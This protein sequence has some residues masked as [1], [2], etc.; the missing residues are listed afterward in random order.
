MGP[1]VPFDNDLKQ[2]EAEMFESDMEREQGA[3]SGA[4][5]H[6]IGGLLCFGLIRQEEWAQEIGMVS[7]QY[8]R[9]PFW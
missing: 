9:F 1:L 6:K 5:V 7:H 3:P 4:V 8:A 2:T